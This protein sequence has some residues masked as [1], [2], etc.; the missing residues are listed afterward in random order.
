MEWTIVRIAIL[1][2]FVLLLLSA[3]IED[4]RTREI[5]DRK[6]IAIALIAPLWW[7]ASGVPVWPDM[8][9]RI[10]VAI[11]VFL[12]FAQAF[13]IG[14][15]GGGDVK[16]IA[17]IALW[18]PLP[19]LF[20]MMLLMSIA[21]GIVTVAMLVDHRLRRRQRGEEAPAIEVPY[22][23]AIAIA[24]LLILREPIFNPFPNT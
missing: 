15:M 9:M 21:G 6:N 17:A 20:R 7:W 23:V 13:R 14:M 8:A 10:A 16:M 12:L 11:T 3:G 18:L 22:G 1:S 2:A 19:P 5:A 4:A 24:A